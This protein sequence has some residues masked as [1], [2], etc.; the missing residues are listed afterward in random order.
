MVC[1]D[2]QEKGHANKSYYKCK[3]YK[4]KASADDG[5]SLLYVINQRLQDYA[6]CFSFD[7]G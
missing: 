1:E 2:C 5:N 7:L 3:Y 6:A 4:K